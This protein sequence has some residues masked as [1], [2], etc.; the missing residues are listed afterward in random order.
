MIVM[1]DMIYV[2]FWDASF[3]L[4][5]LVY[6]KLSFYFVDWMVRITDLM[7]F[8][9]GNDNYM[10]RSIMIDGPFQWFLR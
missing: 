6:G 10:I 2:E 7:L 4:L 9:S 1:F 8:S 5:R 3:L